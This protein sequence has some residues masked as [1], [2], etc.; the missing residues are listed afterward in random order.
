MGSSNS[1]IIELTHRSNL[2]DL[3]S[4]LNTSRIKE[5]DDIADDENQVELVEDIIE[6]ED[7]IEGNISFEV[8][9]NWLKLSGRSI[10]YLL[11]FI[12]MIIVATADA[13]GLWF[14]QHLASDEKIREHSKT[15]Q[16]LYLFVPYMAILV[17]MM[18]GK[19]VK[20]VLIFHGNVKLS[21]EMNFRMTFQT[22]HASINQ[23]F[24]RIPMGRILNR[25]IADVQIV[26]S[27]LPSSTEIV[28]TSA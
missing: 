24:D 1:E 3:A 13:G 8:I 27:E 4:N 9:K 12:A 28:L 15:T 25:F 19:L 26:D 14:T 20:L 11:I 6:S 5:I 16:F 17:V 21:L 23:Y 7:R 22:I 10:Y 18:L 2:I